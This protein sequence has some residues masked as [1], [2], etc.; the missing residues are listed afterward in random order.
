MKVKL[1]DIEFE[2]FKVNTLHE[3]FSKTINNNDKIIVSSLNLHSLF[4]YYKNH[5]VH[6]II[7]N[8][9]VHI[10]GMPII[11]LLKLFGYKVDASFRITWVDWMRPLLNRSQA[12]QWK[13]FYLGAKPGIAKKGF[14]TLKQEFPLLNYAT[15]DGYFSMDKT[16]SENKQIVTIINSFKPNILIVGMGMGRQEE[17]IFQHQNE[18]SCNVIVTCGAAIEYFAGEV[19][20]P[21]RWSGPLGLEWLFRFVDD[22]KRFWY[23]YL[24]EPFFILN[25]LFKHKF[26]QKH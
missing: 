8:S 3:K 25:Q 12:E 4:L 24:V 2:L 14:V 15:C 18:L 21:P 10:D 6:N 1:L 26:L 20:T 17:W 16:K 7:N 13:I 9:I 11:W 5:F 23:R 19:S 22:P